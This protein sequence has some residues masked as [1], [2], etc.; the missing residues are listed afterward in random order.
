[1]TAAAAR[2]PWLDLTAACGGRPG[3]F[4]D[5][6]ISNWLSGPLFTIADLMHVLWE[7]YVIHSRMAGEEAPTNTGL[8]RLQFSL[9]TLMIVVSCYAGLWAL[10]MVYGPASARQLLIVE[11]DSVE[12]DGNPIGCWPEERG[13]LPQRWHYFSATAIAPFVVV[14]DHGQLLGPACGDG[15]T[16]W[17]LWFFGWTVAIR[18]QCG[19]SS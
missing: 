16:S 6:P 5:R 17:V 18:W 2:Y 15:G 13:P 3:R 8:W 12:L 1:L 14:V 10:T 11:Q 19:W 9:R 4:R 7:S